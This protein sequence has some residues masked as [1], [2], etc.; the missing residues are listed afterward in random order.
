MSIQEQ[1]RSIEMKRMSLMER[2]FGMEL[3]L[4]TVRP[5][6]DKWSILE[7]VGH[8]VRF[9]GNVLGHLGEL[10]PRRHRKRNLK[11]RTRYLAAMF[12][13]RFDIPARVPSPAMIPKGD[14]GVGLLQAQ[15]EINH[16]MLRK[17]IAASDQR[18]LR[19]L[20]FSHPVAGPVTMAESLR[21]LEV[22]LDRHIRQI[23]AII[24]HGPSARPALNLS[25]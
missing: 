2:V 22:H 7:I 18:V 10:E 1:L 15:W 19:Q 5:R 13:L 20:L 17:W 4:S 8:L 3:G 12:I 9:E 24:R 23:N 25:I 21:M 14:R 6:P 16:S 11:D